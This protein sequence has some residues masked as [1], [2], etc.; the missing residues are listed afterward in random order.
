M[1]NAWEVKPEYQY[2]RGSNEQSRYIYFLVNT[3]F[4]VRHPI[5]MAQALGSRPNTDEHWRYYQTIPSAQ[6]EVLA[7]Q[8]GLTQ[9]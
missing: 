8:L 4:N 2:A 7:Q 6:A 1:E 3:L 9:Q 5:T